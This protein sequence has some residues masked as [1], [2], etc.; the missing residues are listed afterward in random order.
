MAETKNETPAITSPDQ[1]FEVITPNN[2]FRGERCGIKFFDG[3]GYTNDVQALRD[4]ASH[5]YGYHDRASGKRVAPI[6]TDDQVREE[7]R[8]E[9]SVAAVPAAATPAAAASNPPPVTGAH[10]PA[11]K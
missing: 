7:K 8:A 2:G 4:L 10:S 5:G 11:T 1:R 9:K 3:R 6:K